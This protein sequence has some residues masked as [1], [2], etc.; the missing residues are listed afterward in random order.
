MLIVFSFCHKDAALALKQAN[1]I[2][3]LGGVRNHHA[4]VVC[5]QEA[6]RQGLD[7][8][9]IESLSNSFYSVES[10]SP[11][12]EVEEGWPKSPNH[13]WL[14]TVQHVRDTKNDQPFLWMEAD[15]I[16]TRADWADSLEIEF[17]KWG[18]PFMG[19]KVQFENVPLH[20]SGVAF[21]HRTWLYCPSFS[22]VD[23][24]AWD[25]AIYGIISN[26]VH[27]TPLIQ[28]EW[29]PETFET[30]EDLN[31]LRKGAVVYHQ[32]KDGSLIDRLTESR[33]GVAVAQPVSSPAGVSSTLAPA[34]INEPVSSVPIGLTAS[35][36]HYINAISDLI[37][38]APSRK[39]ILHNELRKAG[40]MSKAKKREKRSILDELKSGR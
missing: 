21:Y 8:P 3:D 31:R 28:H 4:L 27:F 29:K 34:T 38:D 17:N 5:N 37:G 20:M 1:W 26:K 25:V 11:F 18:M 9:V 39:H 24:T 32:C 10:F 6:K 2:K 14:R 12:D 15:A 16:P 22:A 7:T 23:K 36:R 35:I 19:D 33:G 13:M 30:A 40:L